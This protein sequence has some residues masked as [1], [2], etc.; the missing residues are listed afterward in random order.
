MGHTCR[1]PSGTKGQAHCCAATGSST[2]AP[3]CPLHVE[4]IAEN[5]LGLSWRKWRSWPLHNLSLGQHQL[6]TNVTSDQR[7]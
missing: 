5:L 2:E 3:G 4:S 7:S 6:A 1:E